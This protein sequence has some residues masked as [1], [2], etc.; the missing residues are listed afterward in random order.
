[1]FKTLPDRIPTLFPL[2]HILPPF[3]ISYCGNGI[4]KWV[5]QQHPQIT[6]YLKHSQAQMMNLQFLCNKLGSCHFFSNLSF[7]FQNLEQA[8]QIKWNS[9]RQEIFIFFAT[10][11]SNKRYFGSL[12]SDIPQKWWEFYKEERIT[13]RKTFLSWNVSWMPMK[14]TSSPG[15]EF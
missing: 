9:L 10:V 7:S 11:K 12:F 13:A 15:L 14:Y 8:L 3:S 6:K 4:R 2:S 5:L 1:M